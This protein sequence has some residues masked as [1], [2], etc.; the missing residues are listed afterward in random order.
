MQHCLRGSR[1]RARKKARRCQRGSRLDA[2]G[3]IQQRPQV[4]FGF[5]LQ[6]R[7]A[8]LRAACQMHVQQ[9]NAQAAMQALFTALPVVSAGS[10]TGVPAL[11][12]T[13]LAGVLTSQVQQPLGN[14]GALV[15]LPRCRIIHESPCSWMHLTPSPLETAPRLQGWVRT[16]E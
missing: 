13:V 12:L 8:M 1:V 6:A 9:G 16:T 5:W 4:A 3:C 7:V 10:A 11:I 2:K 15:L 14:D